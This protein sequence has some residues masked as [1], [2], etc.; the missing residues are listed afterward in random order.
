MGG[1]I[2]PVTKKS[3]FA[4]ASASEN[5]R[6]I[7]FLLSFPKCSI[8]ERL[9]SSPF[10]NCL[11]VHSGKKHRAFCRDKTFREALRGEQGESWK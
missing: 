11:R 7:E 3:G 5:R 8:I 9:K 4:P 2:R 10:A 1:L 6:R